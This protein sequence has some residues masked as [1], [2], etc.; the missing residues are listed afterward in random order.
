M[1][2][3]PRRLL[4]LEEKTDARGEGH[5]MTEAEIKARRLGAKGHGP[6]PKVRTDFPLKPPEEA[7]PADSKIP[8]S[9]PPDL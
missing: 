1:G 6:P 7:N 8:N 5:V 2:H 9:Q 4:S 3:N